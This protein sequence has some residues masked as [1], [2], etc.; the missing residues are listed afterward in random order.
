MSMVIDTGATRT[1][2]TE[3]DW[4]K[5]KRKKR[6]LKLKKTKTT[7]RPFGVKDRLKCLGKIK[8]KMESR[9]GA[10]IKA[11]VFVIENAKDSLLGI[12]EAERLGV[13]SIFPDGKSEDDS[14]RV[15]TE[16]S[17]KPLP[18]KG[19]LVSDGKTQEEIDFQMKKIQGKFPRVF[20]KKLGKAKDV[21][22]VHVEINK[23]VKPIQQKRRRI[24]IRYVNRFKD[25]LTELKEN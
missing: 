2:L 1:I 10:T 18:G 15:I 14:A 9:S 7:F 5:M 19:E 6:N 13:V 20:S 8:I 22:P 16:F 24:P 23:D 21:E 25:L 17:K 11:T 12:K 3:K 4:E